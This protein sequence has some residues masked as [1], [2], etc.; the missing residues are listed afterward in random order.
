[1]EGH[2]LGRIR[3]DCLTEWL[4][5]VKDRNEALAADLAKWLEVNNVGDRDLPARLAH[6]LEPYTPLLLAMLG[7]A[8]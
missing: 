8:A 2:E 5:I 1:M 7:D 4:A 6:R 3:S